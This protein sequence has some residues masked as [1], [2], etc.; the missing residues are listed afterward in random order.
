MDSEAVRRLAPELARGQEEPREDQRSEVPLWASP[1]LGVEPMQ[2]PAAKVQQE[3]PGPVAF[4]ESLGPAD[5]RGT[6]E[7]PACCAVLAL[8]VRPVALAERISRELR[9]PPISAAQQ[10]AIA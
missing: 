10:D 2:L 1:E 6:P 7:R 9:E 8:E 4:R 5:W 3:G